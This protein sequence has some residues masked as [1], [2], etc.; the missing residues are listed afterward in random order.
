MA[1]VL[2]LSLAYILRVS[3]SHEAI[4]AHVT[5]MQYFTF[6]LI[7]LPFWII[8][9]AILGLYSERHYQNRFSEFGRVA[10]G[11]FIGILFAIG[12]S[13]MVNTPIFPARLVVIYGFF[14]SF[15]AVILFRTLARDIQRQLFSYGVG[16][17]N[18]LIV[19]D[20]RTT[21]ALIDSLANT[22]ITG[23]K[24]IGVIGSEKHPIDESKNITCYKDFDQ[25]IDKLNS[26]QIHTII[27]TELFS[28][29]AKNDEVLTYAQSNHI[30]YRFV[31][32][33]SELFVGNIKVDLFQ[34]TPVI[35]VH[36]TALVGWGRVVK[37][38][39]DIILGSLLLI[40]TSPIILGIIII[41]F[42]LSPKSQIFYRVGRL[43]IF[44]DTVT[45]YKF[46]SLKQ[47]YTNMSPEDG[48]R[49]MSRPELIKEYR[50]NGNQLAHDPRISRF[51]R[52]L[53]LSSLDELPQ[54][55]NIVK[56]DISLVGPRALDPF[57]LEKYPKKNLILAVKSGLTGLAQISGRNN[58][59]FDERRK[60][61]L[62]YV[63]NWTFW[64]DIVILIRTVWV[65]LHKG[66]D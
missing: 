32:G 25:A 53:R 65:I 21:H 47:A 56:G 51:G 17:N 55:M 54:L 36:Q 31:P 19:G 61:D 13:Y 6:L 29:A 52:L 27:Q 2:G 1:I 33:N 50:E 40:L 30:A 9:F 23:Y 45:I 35:A 41:Q 39:T 11:C 58:I 20:N 64:G 8:I 7:L 60:L 28:A 57:E 15:I 16:I 49:K 4:S 46:R 63:Q 12:Y 34:S 59:S 37:R 14:F 43:T 42:V 38:L 48:F 44:G 10:V 62:Y 3:I 66:A 26:K 18:V 5:S 24:V 22:S